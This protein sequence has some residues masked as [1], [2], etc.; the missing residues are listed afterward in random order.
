MLWSELKIDEIRG[1]LWALGHISSTTLGYT[2]IHN[3]DPMFIEWC[4]QHCL[5]N[6]SYSLRGTFFY[7]LGLISRTYE[8]SRKLSEL[9]WDSTPNGGNSAVAIPR[10]SATLFK[11][12]KKFENLNSMTTLFS[13]FVWIC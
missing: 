13:D 1:A 9:A 12:K 5:N 8:G 2:A 6:S 3:F 7:V 4:I 10:N 11:T